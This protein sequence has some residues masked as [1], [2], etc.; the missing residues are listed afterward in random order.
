[1]IACAVTDL[2]Q[3]D[4]PRMPRVS[5]SRSGEADPVDGLGDAVAGVELDLEVLHLQQRRG[6][7]E[8]DAAQRRLRRPGGHVGLGVSHSISPQRLRGSRAS[9]ST[10]PSRMNASTVMTMNAHG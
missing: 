1:M 5:P 7:V 6:R 3:P 10:S 4:S 2:P 9:R 8:G